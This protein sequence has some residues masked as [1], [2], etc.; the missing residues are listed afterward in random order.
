MSMYLLEKSRVAFQGAGERSFH[1]F[2]FMLAGSR[3]KRALALKDANEYRYLGGTPPPRDVSK[4]AESRFMGLEKA[5]KQRVLEKRA[6][7]QFS[8]KM[9]NR[10]SVRYN[11]EGGVDKIEFE[12]ARAGFKEVMACVGTLG[13][14]SAE[15]DELVQLL[16]GVLHIGNVSFIE[17]QDS[18]PEMKGYVSRG[19]GQRRSSKG[20]VAGKSI[21]FGPPHVRPTGVH[22][23]RGQPTEINDAH[24]IFTQPLLFRFITGTIRSCVRVGRWVC[25]LSSWPTR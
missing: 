10:A 17:V 7:R 21:F 3:L 13:F 25:T 16:A 23:T 2:Y 5:E 24:P 6:S 8:K 18:E 11:K 19:V 20:F 12:A 4:D 1:I 9:G 22:R 15:Q 14:S